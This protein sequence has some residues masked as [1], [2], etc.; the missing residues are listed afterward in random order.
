MWSFHALSGV[1]GHPPQHVSASQKALE[2]HCVGV[3]W[4][5]H[6]VGTIDEIWSLVTEL[7]V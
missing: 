6:Y 2:P 4:R 5:F 7:K 1:G 3:L